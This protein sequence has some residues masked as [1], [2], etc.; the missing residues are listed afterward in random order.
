MDMISTEQ[1]IRYLQYRAV[2]AHWEPSA[3]KFTAK[4]T[5]VLWELVRKTLTS[6]KELQNRVTLEAILRKLEK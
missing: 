5:R 3:P 1:Y 4:Q 2:S 6:K